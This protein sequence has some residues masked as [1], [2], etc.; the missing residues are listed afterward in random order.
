[1]QGTCHGRRSFSF[2]ILPDDGRASESCAAIEWLSR[3]VSGFLH[4]L[5]VREVSVRCLKNK[6]SMRGFKNFVGLN[7]ELLRPA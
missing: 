7:W 5:D 4:S 2:H 6:G 1:M 3:M